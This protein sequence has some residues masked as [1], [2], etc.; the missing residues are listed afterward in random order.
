MLCFSLSMCVLN[1]GNAKP[2]FKQ[3]S[4]RIKKQCKHMSQIHLCE[5]LCSCNCHGYKGTV[6]SVMLLY[7]QAKYDMISIPSSNPVLAIIILHLFPRNYLCICLFL[8]IPHSLQKQLQECA[9]ARL[10]EAMLYELIVV[11]I[12]QNFVSLA[13]CIF[14]ISFFSHLVLFEMK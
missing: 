6:V 12:I 9:S 3:C 4:K 1:L 8:F 5:D 10:G 2:S 14:I 7:Y 11:S 13:N